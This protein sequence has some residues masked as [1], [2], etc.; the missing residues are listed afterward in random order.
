MTSAELLGSAAAFGACAGGYA[1]SLARAATRVAL[2]SEGASEAECAD[3][4]SLFRDKWV[5]ASAAAVSMLS[6]AS[7]AIEGCT[8]KGVALAALL[9]VLAMLAAIDLA[10][11]LLPDAM[12]IPLVVVGLLVNVSATIVPLRDAVLGTAIGFLGFWLLY[13]SIR[14]VSRR[15]G[16][17]LGD[18]K[19]ACALG[20]WLGYRPLPHIFAVAVL[21]A[22]LYACVL[23]MSRRISEDRLIPFGPF[24]AAG[25]ALTAF[26]GTPLYTLIAN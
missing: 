2:R 17:G 26:G 3:V 8:A 25:A 15:E 18:V 14:L 13:W 4:T 16:M 20:A 6:G 19:L 24:L 9:F 7:I 10:T 11:L 5:F 1:P 22:G 23:A 21:L 12:T